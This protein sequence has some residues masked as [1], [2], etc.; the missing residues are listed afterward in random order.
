MAATIAPHLGI[1]MI[2]HFSFQVLWHYSI[3]EPISYVFEKGTRG[4]T[5]EL[6]DT[7][8]KYAKPQSDS[9]HRYGLQPGRFSFQQ[10]NKTVPLQAADILAWETCHQMR[11]VVFASDPKP[12]RQSYRALRRE[13]HAEVFFIQ[14]HQIEK[15]VTQTRA[16]EAT[17]QSAFSV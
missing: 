3:I 14:R 12:P 13:G 1:V 5:G 6:L 4:A 10:K 7:L 2:A 9:V 15:W 8:T 17:G 16:L 11:N